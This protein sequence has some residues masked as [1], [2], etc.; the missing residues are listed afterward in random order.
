MSTES[1]N[2]VSSNDLI[3]GLGF[4]NTGGVSGDTDG[5]P[6]QTDGRTRDMTDGGL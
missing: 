2:E 5:C 4:F 3:A 6:Q 1:T